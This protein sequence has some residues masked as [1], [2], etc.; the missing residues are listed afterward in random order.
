MPMVWRVGL[1]IDNYE[2]SL[3]CTRII[4]FP[5]HTIVMLRLSQSFRAQVCDASG[6]KVVLMIALRCSVLQ[7]SQEGSA[8]EGSGCPEG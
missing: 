6:R 5:M 1:S 7:V 8:R 4:E 3:R 2:I